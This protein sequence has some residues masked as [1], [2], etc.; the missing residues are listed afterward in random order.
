[1]HGRTG[2]SCVRP[3]TLTTTYCGFVVILEKSTQNY[4]KKCLHVCEL[5]YNKRALGK[6]SADNFSKQ[7][8]LMKGDQKDMRISSL[9]KFLAVTV[10]AT[11]LAMP[12]TVGATDSSESSSEPATANIEEVQPTSQIAAGGTVIK[13]ETPGAFVVQKSSPVTG[14]AVRETPAQI[15]QAAGLAANET[16][17]VSAYTVDRAKSAAVYASFDGAAATLGGTTLGGINVDLG[18][19]TNGKFTELPEGVEVPF[20]FGIKNYNPNLTYY[21]VKVLPGG[22]TELVPAEVDA[23]GVITFNISGGL[24]GY[25]LIAA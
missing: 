1:M 19:L 24:A 6:V 7:N 8:V 18:K 11:M 2:L 16:P 15:K 17:F 21:I 25:G 3:V 20:S 14:M 9:K 4:V 5:C 22:A 13:N 10:A 12:L 23:N